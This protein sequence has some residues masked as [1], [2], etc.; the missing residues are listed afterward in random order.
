MRIFLV[1]LLTASL[2]AQTA[3]LPNMTKAAPEWISL[4]VPSGVTLTAQ[5]GC[6]ANGNLPAQWTAPFTISGLV[7]NSWPSLGLK[8]DIRNCG[9]PN[10]LGELWV[11]QGTAAVK[12]TLLTAPATSLTIPAL[13]GT[14]TPPTSP[15]PTTVT[16]PIAGTCTTTYNAATN[17]LVLTIK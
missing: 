4:S 10:G 15:A 13:G 9:T 6:A 11:Q 16:F 5:F 1:L 2:H 17:S 8:A 7:S 3:L 12:L 14:P